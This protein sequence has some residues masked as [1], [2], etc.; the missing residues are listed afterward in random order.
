MMDDP[1]LKTAFENW[2]TVNRLTDDGKRNPEELWTYFEAAQIHNAFLL[3]MKNEAWI[4]L[5]GMLR[6]SSAFGVSAYTEGKPDGNENLP[7]KNTEGLHGWLDRE[8]AA[9]GNMP[10][11]WTTAEL[12]NCIRDMFVREKDGQIILGTGVPDSWLKPGKSFSVQNMPTSKGTVSYSVKVNPDGC[13]DLEH[14]GPQDYTTAFR[15]QTCD[16]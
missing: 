8:K 15:F 11:N 16:F 1:D 10:H 9:G 2:Y 4:S 14:S 7:Y 13:I 5:S 6:D 12:I 3:G